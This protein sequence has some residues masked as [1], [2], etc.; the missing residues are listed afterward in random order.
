MKQVIV[1][2]QLYPDGVNGPETRKVRAG[3]LIAQACHGSVNAS[4]NAKQFNNNY[5]EQWLRTGTTKIC[6]GVDTE[7]DLL[8]L[9]NTV[10]DSDLPYALVKDS[11]LTEFGGNATF[12]CLV[13]GPAPHEDIDKI[14]GKLKLL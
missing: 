11:G 7:A 12:T 10:V 6:V 2:R 5:Y 3:K 4:E 13:I 8:K 14:T 1:L 9:Y